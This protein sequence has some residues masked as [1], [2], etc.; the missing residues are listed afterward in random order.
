MKVLIVDDDADILEVLSLGL[1]MSGDHSI[2]TAQSGLQALEKI[3][4]AVRPFDL[5]LL[6]I[7]MPEM[8]G[9]EV[10]RSIR[11]RPRYQHKPKPI[12]MV[13]A[14]SDKRHVDDAF[15]AGATDYVIKPVDFTD[16]NLRVKLAE[17]ASSRIEQLAQST[18]A[19]DQLCRLN[20]EAKTVALS[21]AIPID[22]VDGVLR[23]HAFENYL[24]QLGRLEFRATRLQILTVANITSIYERCTPRD[25]IDE[26]TDIAECIS[27]ALCEQAPVITYFGRGIY[28][29]ATY[30]HHAKP[31]EEVTASIYRQITETGLVFRDGC[32]VPVELDVSSICRKSFLSPK[33][34]IAFIDH[35]IGELKTA[36]H[37]NTALY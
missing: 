2:E 21:D 14:M 8:T 24:A 1:E 19:P 3:D 7:Q 11:A 28:G 25:F 23:V 31:I 26:V 9:V 36:A 6:D 30:G 16:L 27:D 35:M 13:T 12:I 5:F 22:D 29:I 32:P 20:N 15:A 4:H 34:Q 10:C 17:T 33:K 37:S 18:Q